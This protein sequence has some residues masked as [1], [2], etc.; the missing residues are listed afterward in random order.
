MGSPGDV[1]AVTERRDTC[2]N[3]RF[4]SEDMSSSNLGMFECRR[5]SPGKSGFPS[6][7]PKKWCGDHK[8]VGASRRRE[9][10]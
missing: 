4:M 7:K 9:T 3:C 10:I 2:G 8:P 1:V 5:R 6:T